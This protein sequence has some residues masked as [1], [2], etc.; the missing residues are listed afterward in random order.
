MVLGT[1]DNRRGWVFPVGPARSQLGLFRPLGRRE[2]QGYAKLADNQAKLKSARL[3]LVKEF[4]G[5]H[6]F[7]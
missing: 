1:I 5:K 7:L 3:P 4:H 6:S 2:V